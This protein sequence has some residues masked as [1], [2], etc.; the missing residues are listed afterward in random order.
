MT[1]EQMKTYLKSNFPI[2]DSV[3]SERFIDILLA[4]YDKPEFADLSDWEQLGLIRRGNDKMWQA[5]KHYSEKVLI[6]S[7]I[8]GMID[9]LPKPRGM[10]R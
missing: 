10:R 5:L 1:K 6:K 7:K 9:A 8:Q 4:E 3:L 2:Q